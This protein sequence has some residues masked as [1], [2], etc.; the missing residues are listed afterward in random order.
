MARTE[1]ESI[2]S[3]PKGWTG[4]FNWVF[5]GLV[6]ISFVMSCLN[7]QAD[8]RCHDTVLQTL[9]EVGTRFSS[10]VIGSAA[11]ALIATE[12]IKL[13]WGVFWKKVFNKG[14]AE[15]E[16]NMYASWDRWNSRREAAMKQGR[17][18]QEP[19]PK[20]EG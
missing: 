5:Y 7:A 12:G 18:F 13:V 2:W 4:T 17:D 20:L 16:R 1:R 14:A 6:V 3:V 19:P 8:Y 9:L 11:V 10:L 15:G